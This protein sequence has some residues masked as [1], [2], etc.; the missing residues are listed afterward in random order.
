MITINLAEFLLLESIKKAVAK[1]SSGGCLC[2]QISIEGYKDK[3]LLTTHDVE[4]LKSS[5]GFKAE[6]ITAEV[7]A[8][9]P[10]SLV[11]LKD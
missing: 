4:G 8:L 1:L 3:V 11:L 2:T 7:F 5:R 6:K 9:I 10:K